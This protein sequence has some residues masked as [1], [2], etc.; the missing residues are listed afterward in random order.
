[1]RAGFF[2]SFFFSFF[3]FSFSFLS[4]IFK[5]LSDKKKKK[6]KKAFVKATGQSNKL[7]ILA[8]CVYSIQV[9]YLTEAEEERK[10]KVTHN[11]LSVKRCDCLIL[12]ITLAGEN[13]RL[14]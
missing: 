8:S 5:F 13:A 11:R 1:M 2:S 6:K 7:L 10:K 3:L 9:E 12:C 14:K 4:L